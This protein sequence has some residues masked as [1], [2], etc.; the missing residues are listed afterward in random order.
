MRRG[1]AGGDIGA[2]TET[3]ID[4]PARTQLVERGG[5]ASEMRR[6]AHRIAVR[7]EPEPGEVGERGRDIVLARPAAVD[8][9]DP[10]QETAICGAGRAVDYS[11]FRFASFT[12]FA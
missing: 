8:I 7:V 9:V 3:G 6:L 12:S 11:S 10:Q 5:I 4:E 1:E 2:G